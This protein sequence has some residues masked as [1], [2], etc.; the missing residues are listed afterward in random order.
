MRTATRQGHGDRTWLVTRLGTGRVALV[1][2]REV[3]DEVAVEIAEQVARVVPRDTPWDV[4]S[5]A[6]WVATGEA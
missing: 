1:V 2:V 3:A 5:E 6:M 4:T